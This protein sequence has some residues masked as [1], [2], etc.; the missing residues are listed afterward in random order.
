MLNPN[1]T[2]SKCHKTRI[3]FQMVH[4]CLVEAK[5]FSIE[6]HPKSI[7]QNLLMHKVSVNMISQ[8][9]IIELQKIWGKRQTKI[10]SIDLIRVKVEIN[11]IVNKTV[12]GG[13]QNLNLE[14]GKY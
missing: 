1:S 3:E 14:I 9:E 4:R 12:I 5:F 6:T 10:V 13:T 8:S 7:L 2:G 11:S